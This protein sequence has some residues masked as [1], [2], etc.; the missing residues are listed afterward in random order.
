MYNMIVT[1]GCHFIKIIEWSD[2]LV[3]FVVSFKLRVL[4]FVS[5]TIL[6]QEIAFHHESNLFICSSRI[7][8][9]LVVDKESQRRTWLCLHILTIP[10]H[11]QREKWGRDTRHFPFFPPTKE[12]TGWVAQRLTIVINTMTCTFLWSKERCDSQV[13]LSL[14]DR[15]PLILQKDKD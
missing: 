10:W 6:F 7:K 4:S 3:F 1:K 11:W 8:E 14:F 12:K 15:N 13:I 9:K 2:P 5:D